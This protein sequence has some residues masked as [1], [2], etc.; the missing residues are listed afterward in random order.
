MMNRF[1]GAIA[2][3]IL[4]IAYTFLNSK[5][6][7]CILGI[8]CFNS[9]PNHE[10]PLG[11]KLS[12]L[13]SL[14]ENIL[15]SNYAILSHISF[16][17]THTLLIPP[18]SELFCGRRIYLCNRKITVSF[19]VQQLKIWALETHCLVFYPSSATH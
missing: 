9:Y 6:E 16:P 5:L 11:T 15:E 1:W 8:I 19:T 12:Y 7:Y 2:D 18:S 4:S 17:I 3:C 14:H 10:S 13:L